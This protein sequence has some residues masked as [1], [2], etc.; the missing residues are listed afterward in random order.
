MKWLLT[1]S[2]AL[3]VIAAPSAAHADGEY[4][5]ITPSTIQAGFQIEIEAFCGDNV[6]PATVKS[7]AFGVVTITP[8]QDPRSGKF[9]HRGTAT[10]PQDKHARAYPVTMTCPSNQSATT[11]LHVVNF[12][13]PSRGPR[14]GGGA[15]ASDNGGHSGLIVAGAGSLA[16]GAFLLVLARR[17]RQA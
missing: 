2:A 17:R 8:Q 6:N 16:A 4:I 9:V 14:T 3:A 15:L 11:T 12:N 13:V 5:R 10:I 7:E 1:L